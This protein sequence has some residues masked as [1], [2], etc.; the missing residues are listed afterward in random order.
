[1]A[2]T[3]SKVKYIGP[4]KLFATMRVI[5]HLKKKKITKFLYYTAVLADGRTAKRRRTNPAYIN[6]PTAHA[7]APK[8]KL[9][10][11]ADTKKHVCYRGY[12]YASAHAH[13]VDQ[14]MQR[15]T[16]DGRKSVSID[17]GFEIAPGDAGDI[18]VTNQHPW[19]SYRMIF[20]DGS[21]ADTA[22]ALWIAT[23]DKPNLKGKKFG[24]GRLH[25]DA[26]GVVNALHDNYDILLR[27]RRIQKISER[28]E[29]AQ[30]PPH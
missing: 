8:P 13:E 27:R 5:P 3:K 25:Y 4:K 22:T 6:A 7:A 11:Y 14:Y 12:I 20:S 29:T 30:T 23:G 19:G 21:S 24:N 26:T 1:M 10:I 15:S 18:K 2:R 16:Y 17:A 28:G 9:G